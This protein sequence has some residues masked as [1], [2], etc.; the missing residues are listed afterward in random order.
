M[1]YPLMLRT[2]AAALVIAT[3]NGPP[4][5]PG[6]SAPQLADARMTQGEG[7]FT[8]H[9]VDAEAGLHPESPS[10]D[11][12]WV[13]TDDGHA[14]W[15]HSEPI[16]VGGIVDVG[17][18]KESG[19]RVVWLRV[20]DKDAE[21]FHRFTSTHIGDQFAFVLNGRMIGEPVKITMPIA[22]G[23]WQLAASNQVVAYIRCLGFE[24]VR[25]DAAHAPSPPTSNCLS[26]H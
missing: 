4:A 6:A 14:Y 8:V 11:D 12:E 13:L 9:Q 24:R 3:V 17:L 10:A 23:L 15:L 22:G 25:D 16:L 2:A 18:T 5:I 20:T 21:R 19:G 26:S 1:R 7:G